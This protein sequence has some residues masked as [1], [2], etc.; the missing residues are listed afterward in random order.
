MSDLGYFFNISCFHES[1]HGRT[2]S[3][4]CQTV[5]MEIFTKVGVQIFTGGT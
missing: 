2:Y 5:K 1:Q 3:L 4:R